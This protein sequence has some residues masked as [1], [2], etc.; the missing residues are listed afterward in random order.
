MTAITKT[1]GLMLHVDGQLWP[2]PG[3]EAA[4]E[5]YLA[6]IAKAD[7]GGSETPHCEILD[8]DMIPVGHVSYNGR[9]WEHGPEN[10]DGTFNCERC[11]YD[12]TPRR[13]AIPA[14]DIR[15]LG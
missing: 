13:E 3:A 4:S 10:R 6:A 2:Y 11:I 5:I 14:T 7:I 8:A 15:L 9:V 12:P 1:D